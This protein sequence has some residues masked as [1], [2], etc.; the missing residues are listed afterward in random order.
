MSGSSSS[1]ILKTLRL[2]NPKLL[3]LESCSTLSHVK[4]IHAHMIR[5]HFIFDVF[6]AS[7][8]IAFCIDTTLKLKTSFLLDYASRL[9]SQIDNPNLFI[10]NALIRGYSASEFPHQSF[11]FYTQLQRLGL[12]PDNITFP[13]L[14]KSCTQLGSLAIATQA[15]AQIIKHGFHLD[16]YVQ[17]SLVHMY[18]TFGDIQAASHIFR[19]INRLDVVS[20][21]SMIAGYN[22]CGDVQSARQLF[23]R[24]PE[25]NLV[26]WSIMISGYARNNHFEKAIE[27]FQVLQSEGVRAN[28]TVMVSVISSCAHL[29]ALELGERV[30]DY[31]VRNN[32]TV[33]LILGTALVDL[34][35]RCG[36]I[37]KSIQ[38][39]EELPERD[40]LS[41]T[42]LIAGLA[43]HGYAKRA[44]EY[45][46]EMVKTG[47]TP[48]D[49]TFTAVLS[50]CSHGGMLERG[51]KI[52]ESMKR[53]YGLQPRLE[54]YGCMV[55]LLGRA[56][57]LAEAEKFV[58]EMPVK[59][60]A[61]VWGALLGACRIH[62]NAE[63]GERV[64]K[65]LIQLRPE[66]SGYYV[67]L[68]NIYARANK[69]ENVVTMRQM[70][71]EKGVKKP[72]GYSLIEIDGKIHNFTI[73][74]K[75]HPEIK[76][77]EG[78]WDEI[79]RKIRL[80]GYTGNTA[81]ALFDIDEEEKESALYRHSEKLAIAFG[82]MK[83]KARSPIRI[84]KNLRVCEDCHTATK[85]ISEVF[86]RELIVRDRN[87]FHH[88]KGGACSCMDFW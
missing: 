25:K 68:S 78:M 86:E 83:T 66:H 67:L 85:L 51:F 81:D 88:F 36:S 31:V 30:H 22:K 39:F 82:I 2:K 38:V 12:L 52:F 21:T 63:I 9:F 5:T 62:R 14:V 10:Y 48:R 54:H 23:D 72:P 40:V 59:P 74:D 7:R 70:M 47:L 15:H 87:R 8:L 64:G 84:V 73:G 45:F 28:E 29:G 3:L 26:T 75:T 57:K 6:A 16:V 42:T 50:A 24:M 71:K 55:D 77:I 61:P 79:L 53:D 17:N 4:I 34:Y 49:I 18:A 60:N 44:L 65:I 13:F 80:A 37:E 1:S 33:N 56:G 20:W 27:L 41:W 76:K 43:M 69:W 35:A 58:H 46:S 11:H 19:R 32:I